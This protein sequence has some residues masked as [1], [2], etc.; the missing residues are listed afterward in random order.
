MDKQNSNQCISEFAI[1]DICTSCGICSA[2]CPENAISNKLQNG[3]FR[4]DV[5]DKQCIGCGNCTLCC[6][7]INSRKSTYEDYSEFY[8]GHSIDSD[9][10]YMAASGG[11]CTELLIYLLDKGIVDYVITSRTYENNKALKPQVIGR[12]DRYRERLREARGSNYCPSDNSELLSLISRLDGTC[13]IVALPCAQF[14]INIW[15][16][17][18]DKKG[19]VKLILGLLCNHVPSYNATEYLCEEYNRKEAEY[20]R[21]RGYGWYG[22]ASFYKKS[23][24]G[25]SAAK[26]ELVGQAPFW[27]YFSGNFANMFWQNSCIQCRDHFGMFADAA[28]GDASFVK[29]RDSANIGETAIFIR[30]AELI[31]LFNNMQ[32]EGRIELYPVSDHKDLSVFDAI[33]KGREHWFMASTDQWSR[34]VSRQESSGIYENKACDYDESALCRDQYKTETVK[35]ILSAGGISVPEDAEIITWG[36]GNLFR[37]NFDLINEQYSVR[38]V[39]DSNP[40]LQNHIFHP[41]IR[42]VSPDDIMSIHKKRSKKIFVFIA[43]NSA[44]GIHE[45]DKF[46][47][48]FNI[49]HSDIRRLFNC[50]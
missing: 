20:I 9:Y 23:I 6:P 49:P 8:Y 13:T 19:K 38:F 33:G 14:A 43:I 18:F 5:N 22:N 37:E 28:F 46:L 21:Y 27:Q 36:F 7:G 41:G 26:K 35:K 25:N 44:K 31:E 47:D 42:V 2:I 48:Q 15:R 30:N 39:I 10:R 16:K 32:R 24:K 29:A 50:H 40:N 4:P 45:A 1:E 11:V 3:F 17:K 12:N 34:S